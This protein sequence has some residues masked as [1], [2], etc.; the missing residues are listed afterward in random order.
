MLTFE[1]QMVALCMQ[2]FETGL[3]EH[4]RRQ[5]EVDSFFGGQRE[6]VAHYQQRA[7]EIL[8]GFEQQHKVVSFSEPH[9]FQKTWCFLFRRLSEPSLRH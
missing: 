8:A 9:C 2:L 1:R 5:T 7:S 4:K 3:T 6:A